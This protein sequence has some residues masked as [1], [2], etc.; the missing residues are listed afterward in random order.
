MHKPAHLPFHL[1][2]WGQMYLR[3]YNCYNLYDQSKGYVDEY[4]GFPVGTIDTTKLEN[5]KSEEYQICSAHGVASPRGSPIEVIFS[6]KNE[7]SS[8]LFNPANQSASSFIPIKYIYYT[9]C[10]QIVKYDDMNTFRALTTASNEST[11]FVGRRREKHRDS[12]PLQYLNDLNNWR[13]CGTP[14]YSITWPKSNYV[15]HDN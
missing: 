2:A 1:L 7:T 10:D 12:E 11:F 13:E 3:H 6:W 5:D 4:K 14:G 8:N 15:Y 9:E